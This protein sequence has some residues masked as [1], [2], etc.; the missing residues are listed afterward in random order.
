MKVNFDAKRRAFKSRGHTC[1]CHE[2]RLTAT[3]CVH[4]RRSTSARIGASGAFLSTHPPPGRAQA[5][6]DRA[7][8]PVAK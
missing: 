1:D 2:I 3:T 8:R 5:L 6:S 7:S 4:T